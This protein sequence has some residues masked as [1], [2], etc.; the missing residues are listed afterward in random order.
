MSTYPLLLY[1][2]RENA[3]DSTISFRPYPKKISY[4]NEKGLRAKKS[5]PRKVCMLSGEQ[6]FSDT[7]EEFE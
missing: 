1:K 5:P 2:A 6:T 3:A 7:S 4:L